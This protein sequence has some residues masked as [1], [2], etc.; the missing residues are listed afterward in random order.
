MKKA[1]LVD[2][3]TRGRRCESV[4]VIAVAVGGDDQPHI[5]TC[6]RP[7][8]H[9]YR[10]TSYEIVNTYPDNYVFRSLEIRL[11]E[12]SLK[13]NNFNRNNYKLLNLTLQFFLLERINPLS[14][15][16]FIYFHL[17]HP[18]FV[19]VTE[20][21]KLNSTPPPPTGVVEG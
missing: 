17:S 14:L 18:M 11:S 13:S 21:Y 2:P 3:C 16:D 15:Q 10:T 8:V 20:S 1:I 5:P 6:R 12:Y 4:S 9:S 7:R 19:W